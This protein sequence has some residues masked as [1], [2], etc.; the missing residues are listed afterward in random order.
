MWLANTSVRSF[1]FAATFSVVVPSS[2]PEKQGIR[3][4][5]FSICNTFAIS[6]Q[7]IENLSQGMYLEATKGN[8][9]RIYSTS[10]TYGI[11]SNYNTSNILIS[12]TFTASATP[13]VS[14]ATTAPATSR[15]QQHLQY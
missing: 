6:R 12:A 10:N 15:Y 8:R 7:E 14:A 4:K 3:E 13:T 9:S 11:S 2:D 1:D 5:C